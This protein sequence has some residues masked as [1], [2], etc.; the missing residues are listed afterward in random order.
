M[1]IHGDKSSGV[2]LRGVLPAVGAERRRSSATSA[3]RPHERSGGRAKYRVI[4]GSGAGRGT[5]RQ[6]RRS[7]GAAGG[8]GRCDSGRGHPAHARL[9]GGRASFPSACMNTTGGSPSSPCRMPRGCCAWATTSRASACKPRRH[10]RRAA[11]G[12]GPPPSR[13]AASNLETQDWTNEHANFFRSISITK[14]ILFFILSLMVAVAAFNIV[15]TM[16]MVVKDKRRDIAILRTFGASP[17]GILSVF[18]VQGSLIGLLGISG[19]RAARRRGR[20]Q[21]AAAGARSREHCRLQ[22]PGRARVLHERPAGAR[23]RRATSC[24][25]AASHSCSPVSPRCI[26]RRARRACCPQNR[27]ATIRK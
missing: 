4:L 17:R 1:L 15:S 13:S 3:D 9:R 25:S 23:A 11:G 14:R 18:V 12:R 10:V 27:C 24:A 6:S 22:I 21:S 16:V 20:G 5:R 19:G 2:L 26:P 7:G 8:A